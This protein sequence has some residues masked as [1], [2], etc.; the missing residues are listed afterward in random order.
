MMRSASARRAPQVC[1]ASN[2]TRKTAETSV[3]SEAILGE[4]LAYSRY[5]K[6][7]QGFLLYFMR[8]VGDIGT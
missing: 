1:E 2:V 8:S 4:E 6:E 5:R 7:S 3:S